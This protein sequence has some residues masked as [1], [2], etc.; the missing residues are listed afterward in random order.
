M[1]RA[2]DIARPCV[3]LVGEALVDQFPDRAVVGG[4][5]FNVARNLAALGESP[6]MITRLGADEAGTIV[7]DEFARF[8][9]VR[10]GL[11]RDPVRPTG[12]VNVRL[13]ATGHR[14]DIAD[15]VAWDAIDPEAS[16]RAVRATGPSVIC[17]GTLAQRTSISRAA[18]RASLAA[19]PAWRLL[20][21]NL[22]RGHADLGAAVESLE[23]ADAVKVNDGELRQLLAWIGEPM[24]AMFT[25]SGHAVAAGRLIRRFSL[26]S[27][28]VTRGPEGAIAYDA[29]GAAI[30]SG[31]SAAVEVVD[32]VGA[33]D[34][35]ASIV[36]L[37][38]LR[39]WPT[40]LTLSRASSFSSAVCTFRG[41]ICGNLDFYLD[42]RARWGIPTGAARAPH[43][44]VA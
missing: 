8:E 17:F 34:A 4:A 35:F 42:W 25:A 41:A 7:E 5:P 33:G 14:F 30:T 26:E 32:T 21:L 31:P 24:S 2:D 43:A 19:S 44:L 40:P 15:Q 9:M 11:Q 20:D 10:D 28:I 38:R 12:T 16:V 36:I 27:L 13:D 6:V 29:S 22:R 37:G 1:L 39:A 18:V 3:A 23:L